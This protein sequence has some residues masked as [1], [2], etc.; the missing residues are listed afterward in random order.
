MA[1][2]SVEDEPEVLAT[3]PGPDDARAFDTGAKVGRARDVAP[4][5]P[6]AV[7]LGR[8]DVATDDVRLQTTADRLDLGELRHTG[9]R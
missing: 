7:E 9:P 1:V 4:G 5:D 2:W 3:S 8:V 6:G